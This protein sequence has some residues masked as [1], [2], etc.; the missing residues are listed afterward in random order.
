[1]EAWFAPC[2][3]RGRWTPASSS[4]EGRSTRPCCWTPL[5]AW[6]RGEVL[7]RAIGQT[8]E[9]KAVHREGQAVEED[10]VPVILS[11]AA[12]AVP[13]LPPVPVRFSMA[14]GGRGC[15][16]GFRHDTAEEVRGA[17]GG[18]GTIMRTGRSGK[19]GPTQRPG[20]QRGRARSDR[21]ES[22]GKQLALSQGWRADDATA[23]RPA[24]GRYPRAI[25][26]PLRLSRVRTSPQK[27]PRA[28][29]PRRARRVRALPPS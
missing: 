20:R 19:A 22:S 8:R 2:C 5:R 10:G 26:P 23:I 29:T 16:H 1:M 13:M 12:T 18:N 4:P 24:T 28:A 9:E 3:G 21:R 15:A 25:R 11:W 27:G 6:R 14:I 17:P 7:V